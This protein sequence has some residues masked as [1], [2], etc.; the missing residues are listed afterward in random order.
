MHNAV[1][2][3][4]TAP[5]SSDN[6]LC[7][8]PDRHHRSDI[9]CRRVLAEGKLIPELSPTAKMQ[10]IPGTASYGW[11]MGG[12]R[13]TEGLRRKIVQRRWKNRVT[14]K[15]ESIKRNVVC[16]IVVFIVVP[17][18]FVANILVDVAP[19]VN[20][21]VYTMVYTVHATEHATE[22]YRL[23]I[24]ATNIIHVTEQ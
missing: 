16:S 3:N 22:R 4:N 14:L 1:V 7:Y 5:N 24:H 10:D 12:F 8:P 20:K 21:R 23:S 11:R 2:H 13:G 6:F 9:V 18:I 17:F 19:Y 15:E